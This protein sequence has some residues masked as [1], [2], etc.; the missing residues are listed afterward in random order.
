MTKERPSIISY[1][2]SFFAGS[3]AA[4]SLVFV[5]H[6]GWNMLG[7]PFERG[8][9]SEKRTLIRERL[10][11]VDGALI[12]DHGDDALVFRF[13]P[14]GYKKVGASDACRTSN[15]VIEALKRLKASGIN[16]E[17]CSAIINATSAKDLEKISSAL[18]KSGVEIISS[19]LEDDLTVE[20]DLTYR[21]QS[22]KL[23]I[24]KQANRGTTEIGPN[25]IANSFRAI[26]SPYFM[27]DTAL[28]I[29]YGEEAL[30]GRC[31]SDPDHKAP[32]AGE[33]YDRTLTV[34][35]VVREMTHMLRREGITYQDCFAAVYSGS[36]N[37]L[38][39]VLEE[40]RTRSIPVRWAKAEVELFPVNSI[41][42]DPATNTMYVV[43]D[44][45]MG[46]VVMDYLPELLAHP[47][48]YYLQQMENIE[49]SYEIDLDSSDSS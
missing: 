45:L 29:D 9:T 6:D 13:F 42:Y 25:S 20:R 7:T 39:M 37:G 24:I 21:P 31:Y 46:R 4:V 49:M 14:D 40:L 38:R 47:K 48:E 36:E 15:V 1:L 12:L 11:R 18:E 34:K 22:D 41:Y 44:M 33:R 32:A 2:I 8:I 27:G 28:V 26:Y 3:L 35:N 17:E 10:L 30:F 43:R 23:K 16:P 5:F 19:I